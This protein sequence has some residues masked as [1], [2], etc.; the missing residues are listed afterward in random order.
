MVP[1]LDEAQRTTTAGTDPAGR[2][3]VSYVDRPRI[4][5]STSGPAA[6]REVGLD[7]V[8]PSWIQACASV[9]GRR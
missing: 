3:L 1:S 8:Q 9:G 5:G 4:A 2:R 7:V 6:A